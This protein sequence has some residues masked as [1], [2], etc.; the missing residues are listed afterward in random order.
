MEPS[1]KEYRDYFTGAPVSTST[2]PAPPPPSTSTTPA[3]AKSRNFVNYD[4]KMIFFHFTDSTELMFCYYNFSHYLLSII[5][6]KT[7][8][9]LKIFSS[10]VQPKSVR[11][12]FERRLHSYLQRLRRHSSV[13]RW[14]GR[15][16]WARLSRRQDNATT[17]PA[18]ATPSDR[19]LAQAIYS[20]TAGNDQVSAD[21]AATATAWPGNKIL[22]AN[23]LEACF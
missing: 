7:V 15:G 2:T 5:I 9:N 4:N 8:T 19:T 10:S 17:T 3:P 21:D 1:P 12:S 20:A 14:L 13:R 16:S 18:S 22:Q 11:M 6:S 23:E